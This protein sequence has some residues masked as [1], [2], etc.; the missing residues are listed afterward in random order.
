MSGK[1]VLF[2]IPI[3]SGDRAVAVY[4]KVFGWNLECWGPMEYGTTTAGEGKGI[5][6]EGNR[7]GLFQDDPKVPMPE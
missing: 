2:E 6:T 7:V 4:A 1:V 5:D 3:D